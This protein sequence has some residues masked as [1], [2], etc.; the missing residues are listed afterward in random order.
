MNGALVTPNPR[1][2]MNR[3]IGEELQA[4][5]SIKIIMILKSTGCSEY[6]KSYP[7]EPQVIV[8]VKNYHENGW[9]PVSNQNQ[10]YLYCCEDIDIKQCM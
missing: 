10:Y 6:A 3:V 7:E 8:S 9:V 5:M 2:Y 4:K 1:I